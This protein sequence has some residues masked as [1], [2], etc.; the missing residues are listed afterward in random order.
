MLPYFNNNPNPSKTAENQ[1]H[2]ETISKIYK[3]TILWAL[4]NPH[5]CEQGQDQVTRLRIILF[6]SVFGWPQP[7]EEFQNFIKKFTFTVV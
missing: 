2:P 5:L 3:H 7:I 1:N 4:V 6:W